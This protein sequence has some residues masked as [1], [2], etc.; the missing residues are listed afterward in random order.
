V[1]PCQ[2]AAPTFC[3]CEKRLWKPGILRLGESF[4]IYD[5]KMNW[6]Q[7][8]AGLIDPTTTF[9]YSS[10]RSR[11]LVVCFQSILIIG[12]IAILVLLFLSAGCRPPDE[13]YAPKNTDPGVAAA[14]VLLGALYI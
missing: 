9:L 8:N 5:K 10:V 7:S 12:L 4:W 13:N 3:R 14:E 2:I 11:S 1:K 6:L